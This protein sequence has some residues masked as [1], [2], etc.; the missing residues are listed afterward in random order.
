VTHSLAHSLIFNW[1]DDTKIHTRVIY[2]EARESLSN[3]DTKMQRNNATHHNK[4]PTT[5]P[6]A[7]EN[8]EE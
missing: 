3:T 5:D 2:V 7:N 8:K 1:K 6:E 4:Q